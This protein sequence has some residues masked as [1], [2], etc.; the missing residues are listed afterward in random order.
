MTRTRIPRFGV[1]EAV[2][3]EEIGTILDLGV[4]SGAAQT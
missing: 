1:P 4:D 2:L 3:N